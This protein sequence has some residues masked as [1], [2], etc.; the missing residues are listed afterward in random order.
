M[1]R[2]VVDFV[3]ARR[4]P[5]SRCLEFARICRALEPFRGG[6]SSPNGL[7]RRRSIRL[8]NTFYAAERCDTR[9]IWS[10]VDE[11]D[12]GESLTS[13]Q[14]ER[15]EKHSISENRPSML[16]RCRPHVP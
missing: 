16:T 5:V 12:D 11:Q 9:K 8:K 4:T 7:R 15:F 13:A 1:A 10:V 3:A 2:L 14:N 6:N